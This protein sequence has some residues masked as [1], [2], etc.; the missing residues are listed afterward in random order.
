MQRGSRLQPTI[1]RD[2]GGGWNVV[3]DDISMSPSFAVVLR[4]LRRNPNGSRQVRF[5]NSFFADVSSAVTGTI[6]DTEY[7]ADRIIAVTST[8][9]IATVDGS[10]TVTAIWNNTI[11]A[12][13][14]G[15]PSGWSSG[16]DS[17]DFVPFR[18]QL[19]IHNG[20]DKPVTISPAFAVTYLQDLGTGS[21]V[22]TP[23]GKY[24]CVVS[25]YHCVAGIPAAET[26]VYVSSQSTAGTFPGDPAPND[27]ITIDVGA[28]A[29][30]GSSE[31]R[32]IAGFRTNLVIFFRGAALV[33]ELGNYVGAVH[34]PK[35]P[36]A[37]ASFGL[38]GHRAITIIEQDILFGGLAGVSSAKRS[39][40]S[41]LLDGSFLTGQVEPAYRGAI[42]ELT[43]EQRL[44]NCFMINDEA[45]HDMMFFVPPD[46][47]F[48][49][50]AQAKLGYESWSYYTEMD[51]T[52]GCKSFLGRIFLASGTRIYQQ[53]NQMFAN[54]N[55]FAD[56]MNDY[57]A[58]W[59]PLT[60]FNIGTIVLDPG[61]P[62]G[63][64][65]RAWRVSVSHTSGAGT[66]QQDRDAFPTY[67]RKYV[68]RSISFDMELPWIQGREPMK[69]KLLRYLNVATK[70]TGGFTLD[71]YVDNLYKD[72]AG[73][74]LYDP[75]VSMDFVGNDV[76]GFGYE[77]GFP[78]A[79]S[80]EYELRPDGSFILRPD[81]SRI[82]RIADDGE[83]PFGSGRRSLDPRLYGL[84]VKCKMMKF[85]IHGRTRRFLQFVNIAFAYARGNYRR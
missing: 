11:A 32:G 46:K 14:P 85:R 44:K 7:F 43:D 77:E 35:F 54:E 61:T 34:T 23:I 39:L 45:N 41:G 19:V 28:Y 13:L 82:I 62:I 65:N 81:G 68:G 56:K 27:S 50:S 59:A 3:D 84:P 80:T 22:N 8:G 47:V 74:V 69:T 75:A 5:G 53:G 42:Q 10:G 25:N 71:V 2:F 18:Q 1:L 38:L 83:G 26:T 31:I 70:G 66:F 76:R 49:R 21:N 17:I 60:V 37:L 73:S 51:W 58:V 40:F 72:E 29:P 24:G 36:D 52:C 9:Q 20:V 57:T 64:V 55:Y 67:W 48:V 4:N 78:S 63:D 16:L 12:L 79:Q 30:E 33:I 15:T 6:V